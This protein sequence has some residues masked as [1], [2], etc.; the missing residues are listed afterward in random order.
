MGG[1][2]RK[3]LHKLPDMEILRNLESPFVPWI[4]IDIYFLASTSYAAWE[5]FY[6]E[7]VDVYCEFLQIQGKKVSDAGWKML[8]GAL[9]AEFDSLRSRNHSQIAKRDFVE[10]LQVRLACDFSTFDRTPVKAR[11]NLD[12]EKLDQNF[13]VLDFDLGPFQPHRNRLNKEVVGWRHGVAHGSAPYL[14]T[15]DAADQISFV[16]QVMMLVSDAFQSAMLGH[17]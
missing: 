2:E 14:G 1:L 8:V 10:N 6:N 16:G 5:G 13:H 17:I 9:V 4:H 7:C 3:F 12:W 11:S 15:L